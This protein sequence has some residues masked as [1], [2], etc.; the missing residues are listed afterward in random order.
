MKRTVF[1]SSTYQDLAA[2]RRAVWNVLGKFSVAVR[3]MEQFG[4]RTEGP[5]ETCLAEVE[6][7]DIYV[8]ILAFR[9]GSMD[10]SAGKSFT[11]LEYERALDL[12][13]EILIYLIDEAEAEV[14]YTDIDHEPKQQER[15]QSF[16]RLLR[17]RHTVDTFTTPTDLATK[18]ER[19]FRKYFAPKPEE[20]TKEKPDEFDATLTAIKRFLKLPKT[21]S[22][23]EVRLRARISSR[24]AAARGLC[25]AF[26][27]PYGATLGAAID[28]VKPKGHPIKQ[29]TEL[30]ATGKRA[31]ELLDRK[32]E[33]PI[34]LYARLQ[35]SPK[36]VHL[37]HAQ[38]FGSEYMV[39]E[40]NYD[41]GTRWEPGEGKM[42]LLFSKLVPS[43]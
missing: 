39:A 13:K 15:L 38:F 32:L 37:T 3:G 5:L 14:R 17:E 19:D 11:Q 25:E 29:F 10:E 33:G 8:G 43:A 27:L 23:T 6:Q 18:L 28:I 40:L 12:G 31:E 1:I 20:A 7:S 30:Y 9:L 34:D 4:A 35:F 21:V 42:I 41:D 22:G 26:N 2:H 36:D 16:K 24:F